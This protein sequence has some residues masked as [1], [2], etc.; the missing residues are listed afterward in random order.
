VRVVGC[1][2]RWG[3]VKEERVKRRIA[4][5]EAAEVGGDEV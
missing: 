1:N 5:A 3:E 2:N 4:A